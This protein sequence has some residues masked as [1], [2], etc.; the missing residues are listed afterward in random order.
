[1]PLVNNIIT[2]TVT[3]PLSDPYEPVFLVY[4][5]RPSPHLIFSVKKYTW[6]LRSSV[7]WLTICIFWMQSW[8]MCS[9]S[10]LREE[11]IDCLDWHLIAAGIALATA[12]VGDDDDE[13]ALLAFM[14]PSAKTQERFIPAFSQEWN[15][16]Y[17]QF[18]RVFSVMLQFPPLLHLYTSLYL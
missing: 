6:G 18:F 17:W 5:P 7:C 13:L 10:G 15:R 12:A 16:Q 9:S 2:Y 4:F 11:I 1:M 14:S 3:S 8:I